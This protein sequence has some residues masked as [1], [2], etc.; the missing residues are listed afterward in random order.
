M[1]RG[2]RG[3]NISSRKREREEGSLLTHVEDNRLSSH[4]V[5]IRLRRGK[6]VRS[7]TSGRRTGQVSRVFTSV[8]P[9]GVGGEGVAIHVTGAILTRISTRRVISVSI[10]HSETITLTRRQNVVFVSRV[11]GV[12]KERNTSNKPSM[13][14]RKIRQSV[15]PVIRKTA[16][17]AGC[18]QVGA[19]RVLFVTTNT[20]RMSGPDSLVPRLRK[21]FPVHM[22]LGDLARRS[23]QGVL[24]RPQRTL[25]QRC[26]TL[27]RARNIAIAFARSSIDTVTRVTSIIGSRARSVNTEQLCAVLRQMLRRLSFRTSRLRGGRIAVSNACI[28]RGLKRVAGSV[29]ASG[30]VLWGRRERPPGQLSFWYGNHG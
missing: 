7:A 21:Q 6:G 1:K 27:L 18:K 19:S 9:G 28:E 29:S 5:R 14:H 17:G 15:L 23:L 16:I 2:T 8:V 3:A 22:R 30:C 12:T 4:R 13:S 24:A 10:I 26:A 11:S 25:V 20:F